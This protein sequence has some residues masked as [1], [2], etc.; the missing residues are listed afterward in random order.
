MS[1]FEDTGLDG[2]G[3]ELKQHVWNAARDT[4]SAWTGACFTEVTLYRWAPSVTTRFSGVLGSNFYR[5]NELH[6]GFVVRQAKSWR[7]AVF[8][9][10]ECIQQAPF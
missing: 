5:I 7:N 1:S 4:I 10:S 3:E 2:A 9:G 8:M 6:S